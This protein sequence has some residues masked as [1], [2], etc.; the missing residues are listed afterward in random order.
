MNLIYPVCFICG[1]IFGFTLSRIL[2]N[3][4]CGSYNWS[5]DLNN[6]LDLD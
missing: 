1:F 6:H 2:K 5:R 4:K 3:K